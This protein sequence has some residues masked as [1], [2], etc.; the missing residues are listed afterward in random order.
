MRMTVKQFLEIADTD[1]WAASMVEDIKPGECMVFHSGYAVD[2]IKNDSEDGEDGFQSYIIDYTDDGEPFVDVD[3][4]AVVYVYLLAEPD[5]WE[6]VYVS[7]VGK[8]RALSL[9]CTEENWKEVLEEVSE[10][11]FD[12][13]SIQ[14]RI[15]DMV[16]YVLE[17]RGEETNEESADEEG[18]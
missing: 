15:D 2:S 16:K 5:S 18:D 3:G 7:F 4:Q 14:E 8:G 13:E 9:G 6:R 11:V 10:R 1:H 12:S 17:E